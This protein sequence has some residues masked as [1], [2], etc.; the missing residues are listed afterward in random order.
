MAVSDYI[1]DLE[2]W[3]SEFRH[4]Y[5]VTVRFSETDAFGHLNNTVSF[6]YFEQGRINFFKEIGF[7]EE[8]FASGGEGIPVTADLHCDYRRQVFFDEQ[9]DVQVKVAEIGN[10]SMDLHYLITNASGK[11]CMTGRGRMVQVSRKTGKPIKWSETAL[12]KLNVSRS[13]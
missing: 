7:G 8:W 2:K 3:Q 4:S 13:Q 5:P 6:V 12:E 9:L 1:E 11:V 10:S